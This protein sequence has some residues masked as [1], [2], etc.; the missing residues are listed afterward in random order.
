MGGKRGERERGGGSIRERV[1]FEP[2]KKDCL[3]NC[4]IVHKTFYRYGV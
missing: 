3:E 4:C 2:I 1:Y